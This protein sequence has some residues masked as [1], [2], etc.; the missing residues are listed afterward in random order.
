MKREALL[1]GGDFSHRL[2]RING[3][4]CCGLRLTR[5]VGLREE[6]ARDLIKLPPLVAAVDPRDRADFKMWGSDIFVCAAP[7]RAAK[8]VLALKFQKLHEPG[9]DFLSFA[10][11]VVEAVDPFGG[12]LAFV[13]REGGHHFFHAL[14]A[15]LRGAHAGEEFLFDVGGGEAAEFAAGHIVIL[16]R[17]GR[18]DRADGAEFAEEFQ[19]LA[20]RA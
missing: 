3:E 15:L 10:E 17:A 2:R 5:S 7:S 12:E 18:V 20:G 8:R 4:D 1:R 9:H 14:D 11:P 13:F 6:T 16:A 19:A